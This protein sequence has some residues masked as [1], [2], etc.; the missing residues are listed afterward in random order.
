MRAGGAARR[1]H[2]ADDVP[3]LDALTRLD[4]VRAQVTVTRRE[5]EAVL[6]DDQIAVVA[7]VRRRIDHAIGGRKYRLALFGRD[8]QS[9]VEGP[10]AGGRSGPAGARPRPPPARRPARPGGGSGRLA[11]R[12]VAGAAA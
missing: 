1:T 4:P 11:G 12:R 8:V 9:P 10:H 7:G 2:K 3:A 5:P 6:E